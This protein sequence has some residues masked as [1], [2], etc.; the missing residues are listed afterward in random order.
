[1]KG[2]VRDG[3]LGVATGDAL[4]LPVQFADRNERRADPVTGMRGN[5]VFNMPAGTW[6]DDTSLTL[7]L[8]DSLSGG[9]YDPDDIMKKF[10]LWLVRGEYTPFGKSFD[11]GFGTEGTNA[12]LRDTGGKSGGKRKRT[13]N[14]PH[15]ILPRLLPVSALRQRVRH[16]YHSPSDGYSVLPYPCA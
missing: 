11:I 14:D 15:A 9:K 5:G 10:A 13:K 1:M 7:C 2:H 16:G 3:I 4:G 8:L 6:S 12:N